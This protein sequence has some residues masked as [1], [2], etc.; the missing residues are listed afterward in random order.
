MKA[1]RWRSETLTT[2]TLTSSFERRRRDEAYILFDKLAHKLKMWINLSCPVEK[3]LYSDILTSAV[4]LHQYIKCSRS[5]YRLLRPREIVE[6]NLK[7]WKLKKM[8]TWRDET[9]R[10]DTVPL[11]CLSPSLHRISNGEDGAKDLMLTKPVVVVYNSGE[12]EG[13]Y[14]QMSESRRSSVSIKTKQL[15]KD[16][17][18]SSASLTSIDSRESRDKRPRSNLSKMKNF[19][20]SRQSQQTEQHNPRPGKSRKSAQKS[21]EHEN[22]GYGQESSRPAAS[23]RAS[24]TSVPQSPTKAPAP[25]P[26][27][28]SKSNSSI[29]MS[30]TAQSGSEDNDYDDVDNDYEEDVG[31]NDDDDDTADNEHRTPRQSDANVANV[32]RPSPQGPFGS[33]LPQPERQRPDVNREDAGR[34]GYEV[35]SYT[36]YGDPVFADF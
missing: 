33:P 23:K 13:P 35:V 9:A 34:S 12:E 29:V 36:Q 25:T 19:L 11:I 20:S 8:A 22:Y 6:R 28:L 27:S 30:G 4:T 24:R 18:L 15:Q 14:K 17:R 26:S 1:L 32:Y 16:D 10:G 7:Q 5:R 3:R 21:K 31:Y 2:M